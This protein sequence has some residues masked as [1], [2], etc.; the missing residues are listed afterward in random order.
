[1]RLDFDAEPIV[2]DDE[3]VRTRLDGVPIG[4]LLAA[5]AHMT[6]EYGLLA[7][8]LRPDPSRIVMMADDGYTPEQL[9]RGWDLAADALIRFRDDG[10]KPAGQPTTE[11][12][13]NLIEFE[14]CPGS[15]LCE[16]LGQAGGYYANLDR[17]R[18][19]GVELQAS[20]ALTPALSLSA[21]YSHIKTTD[22][23]P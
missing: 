16:T 5:V 20:A 17:A 4:A 3:T 9:E 21:N 7:D 11:Q 23:T 13:R 14:S 19:S 15:A 1:M 8:D 12:L 10:S 6:G 18:A 22:E 2:D